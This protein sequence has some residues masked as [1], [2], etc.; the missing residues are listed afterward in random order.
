VT[1][2]KFN[3]AMTSGFRT[4]FILEKCPFAIGTFVR[5]WHSKVSGL[6]NSIV[7]IYIGT[8]YSGLR[9]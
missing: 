4:C 3:E 2:S 8:Y 1:K 6:W 5:R 7:F 9:L